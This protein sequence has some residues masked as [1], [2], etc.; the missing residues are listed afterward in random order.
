[1]NIRVLNKADAPLYQALRLRALTINPEAFESTY[2]KEVDYTLE[3]ICEQISPTNNRFMLGAFN[4]ENIL[5]GMVTFTREN[6]PKIKHKGHA[7]SLFIAPEGR[8]HGTGKLLMNELIHRA[9]KC[10]GLEQ[11]NLTVASKNVAAKTLYQS[12]G[13]MTYGIEKHSFKFQDVYYD[14]D[15]MAIH[16]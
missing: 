1:M 2:Q 3:I 15:F 5:I 16:I 14:V 11:I 7:L 10:K 13:F 9:K 8:K 6:D 4:N 12:L